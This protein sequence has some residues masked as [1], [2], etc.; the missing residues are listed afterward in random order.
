MAPVAVVIAGEEPARERLTFLDEISYWGH[1]LHRYIDITMHSSPPPEILY[2]L[3]RP[4]QA[5]VGVRHG[6]RPRG[7]CT[8]LVGGWKY[9]GHLVGTSKSSNEREVGL[10]EKEKE[11]KMPLSF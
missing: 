5:A 10:Q 6:Q 3:L 2:I 1:I 11:Q 7:L 4:A 8:S 9:N